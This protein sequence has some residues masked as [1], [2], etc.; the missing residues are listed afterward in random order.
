MY[1]ISKLK[2]SRILTILVPTPYNTPIIK[3]RD[4][5]SIEIVKKGFLLLLQHPFCYAFVLYFNISL[6]HF[7]TLWLEMPYLVVI[8]VWWKC[9]YRKYLW[10][11]LQYQHYATVCNI[12]QHYATCQQKRSAWPRLGYSQGPSLNSLFQAGY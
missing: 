5:L 11:E 3:I 4:R 1:K 8:S 10:V 6:H 2:R 12:M 7:K 9:Q